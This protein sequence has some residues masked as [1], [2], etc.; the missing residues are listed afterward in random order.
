ML[1][2]RSVWTR[3]AGGWR[4]EPFES[5]AAAA[6]RLV[7]ILSAQPRAR[8]KLVFEPE[9]LVHQAVETPRVG[10]SVF[11][12]LSRV[13]GEFPVVESESLGWGIEHPEPA[14]GGAYSTLLHAE[15]TPALGRLRDG[16]M[17]ATSR[18]AAAWSAYTAGVACVPTGISS[19]RTR[20]L[21]ILAPGFAA[22]A[23]CITG[24]RSFKAW[25]GPMTDRDWKGFSNVIGDSDSRSPAA[26][27]DLGMRRGG[28]AIIAEGDPG[29][30]CPLWEE[31][32]SSGRVGVPV[33]LDEL[34]TAASRIPR[35]HPANL[36]ETFPSPR[37]M[38][39]CLA[40]AVAAGA[41]AALW[42]CTIGADVRRRLASEGAA[43]RSRQALLEER[44]SEL[45]RNQAEMERLRGD[46][47][48]DPRYTR[49]PRH[50]ALTALAALIPE[51]LTVT[52]LSIHSDNSFEIKAQVMGAGFDAG[53]L[54][55]ELGR[56]CLRPDAGNGW[57]FNA[58]SGRL[59]VRGRLGDP[60]V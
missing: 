36:V 23:T 31:I 9:G 16:C 42:L 55:L 46:V 8:W 45:A 51:A 37:D 60:G 3:D 24:R 44:L 40:G 47:P 41:A 17:G 56:S 6:K 33:G 34:A 4:R 10:R 52:S 13:R 25:S 22:V 50:L 48:G 39:P 43:I 59:E 54:R 14:Q 27:A 57:S 21:A 18:L 49:F 35:G 11:A 5:A 38:D 30:L 32:K 58:A 1:L 53:E 28:I 19:G 15:A 7:E 12:S 2:G 26:M 20:F 29:S